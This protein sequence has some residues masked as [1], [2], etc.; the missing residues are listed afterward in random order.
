MLLSNV[1]EMEFETFPDDWKQ[2]PLEKICE[3]FSGFAFKSTDFQPSGIPIV[4]IGNLQNGTIRLNNILF[5]FRWTGA[6]APGRCQSSRIP[7]GS[8]RPRAYNARG[9]H[10][11]HGLA[12]AEAADAGASGASG[13]GDAGV[14]PGVGA[15]S[16]SMTWKD[17]IM[18]VTVP[19]RPMSGPRL[20]SSDR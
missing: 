20:P 19:S 8:A 7:V 14:P 4:K 5:P 10:P 12:G 16:V 11:V 17:E 2:V 18:P 9:E 6:N 15:F 13:G 1:T 3:I